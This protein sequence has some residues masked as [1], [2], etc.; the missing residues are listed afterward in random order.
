MEIPYLLI[1]WSVDGYL[2]YLQFLA[3]MNNASLNIPKQILCEP[4]FSFFLK[5]FIGV[6]IL[7]HLVRLHLT[8]K[9]L[10]KCF[11]KW[12]YHFTFQPEMYEGLVSHI[13]S[14]TWYCLSF[15]KNITPL[16]DIKWYLSVILICTFLI[17]SA[18]AMQKTWIWSLDQEDPLEKEMATHSSSLAW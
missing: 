4:I 6:E 17:T 12:I 8:F 9:K 1:H 15:L 5:I 2:S 3:V 13:L 11:P 7:D 10:S 14:Y 16:V 18:S